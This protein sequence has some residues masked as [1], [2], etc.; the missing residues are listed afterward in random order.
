MKGFGSGEE[1]IMLQHD[2]VSNWK[3]MEE[4]CQTQAVVLKFYKGTL[5]E[6]VKVE[7]CGVIRSD[8]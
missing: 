7:S 2:E 3:S 8:S 6:M 1:N 5:V 4:P